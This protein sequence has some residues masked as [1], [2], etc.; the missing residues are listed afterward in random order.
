ML[1]FRTAGPA[2][3]CRQAAI[4]AERELGRRAVEFGVDTFIVF[5]THWLVNAGYHINN[6]AVHKATTPATSS[7]TSFRIC[8]TN[9]RATRNWAG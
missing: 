6:K 8:P 2:H 1:Y 5:D 4:D 3:G 9:S 7:R